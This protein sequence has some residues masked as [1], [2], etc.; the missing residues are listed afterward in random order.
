[1]F[2]SGAIA[3]IVAVLGGCETPADR[4]PSSFPPSA[5]AARAPWPQLVPLSE[6]AAPDGQD[7]GSANALAPEAQAL[8]N[9]A[10]ALRARARLASGAI[11]TAA[12]RARL[13]AAAARWTG[14]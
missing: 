3:L 4:D 9:R 12:E 6:L 14:T 8:A 13:M 5:F 7:A 2:R 10:E 1:M 11:L